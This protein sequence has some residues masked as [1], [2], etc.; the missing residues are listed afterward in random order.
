MPT[1]ISALRILLVLVIPAQA[2]A[3]DAAIAKSVSSPQDDAGALSARREQMLL[4]C[5]ENEQWMDDQLHG[6]KKAVDWALPWAV[7]TGTL[8]GAAAAVTAGSVVLLQAADYDDLAINSSIAGSIGAGL[9]TA[10]SAGL[11]TF[12]FLNTE[13][14]STSGS[15]VARYIELQQAKGTL[16]A[17]SAEPKTSSTL[18]E[19]L[20][21]AARDC[22]FIPRGPYTPENAQDARNG[23]T[24][25][26]TAA[27]VVSQA[28]VIAAFRDSQSALDSAAEAAKKAD[29]A[30][31]AGQ[32]DG[33]SLKSDLSILK[34]RKSVVES[35]RQLL[36]EAP[37][38]ARMG[39]AEAAMLQTTKLK[40]ET[41]E[42][43]SA[44]S[45]Q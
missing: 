27:A 34:T 37:D 19:A 25:T 20:S 3:F 18:Q 2:F 30:V 36:Q 13:D 7:A 28:I 26:T 10:V 9:L 24:S 17:A 12:A 21:T 4:H 41:A 44:I 8:A 33:T 1:V 43:N 14:L 5:A 40:A 15:R 35:L 42:V 6:Q 16:I 23:G 31:E 39:L 38:S 22:V 29:A 32:G 45:R 11:G